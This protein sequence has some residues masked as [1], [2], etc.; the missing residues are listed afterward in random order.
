MSDIDQIHVGESVTMLRP[1]DTCSIGGMQSRAIRVVHLA[2]SGCGTPL[3]VQDPRPGREGLVFGR[4]RLIVTK[5]KT[6]VEKSS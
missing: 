3:S 4:L 1:V 5:T 2:G 6:C